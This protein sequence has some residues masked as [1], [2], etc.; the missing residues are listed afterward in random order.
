M[1]ACEWN[2]YEAV[3]MLAELGSNVN[4]AAKDGTTALMVAATGKHIKC[5]KA[6]LDVK[7]DVTAKKYPITKS[8]DLEDQN[9]QKV[10]R[11]TYFGMQMP[12]TLSLTRVHAWACVTQAKAS[13]NIECEQAEKR[14]ARRLT[15]ASARAPVA[16]AQELASRREG[17]LELLEGDAQEVRQQST[18][19]KSR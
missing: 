3:N 13:K 14:S 8:V 12:R 11:C 7:A 19:A 5:I 17:R 10:I 9:K 16:T 2:K 4:A 1:L 15:H 6:L 18:A